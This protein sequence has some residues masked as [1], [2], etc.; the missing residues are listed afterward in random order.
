[1]RVNWWSRGSVIAAA[2]CLAGLG[3][4][5]Q[6]QSSAQQS[7]GDPVA[8]AARRA[9]EEK[10]NAPKPKKV[11]TDEDVN[12]SVATPATAPANPPSADN[13]TGATA[14]TGEQKTDDTTKPEDANSE[15]TWRK[16]FKAQHDKI[17]KAETELNVLQREEEK[18]QVQYYPD[19]Q[20]ALTQ[21]NTRGDINERA[22]K[23]AAK[24]QEI[25]ELKQAMDDMEADLRKAGGDPGWAR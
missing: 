23:I 12:H 8:D 20:K 9:R 14:A 21:Q 18:G 24:K 2:L 17:A 22:S 3:A 1:M 11:F 5:A 4:N 6:Q 10:K 13:S 7:S 19:P 16:R 25:A 15:A